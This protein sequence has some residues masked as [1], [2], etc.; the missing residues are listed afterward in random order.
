MK[1]KRIVERGG[2]LAIAITVCVFVGTVA[3]DSWNATDD[4]M[5]SWA[6]PGD[7]F[8]S[9]NPNY[10]WV[11]F[12]GAGN[13]LIPDGPFL[14]SD[15]TGWGTGSVNNDFYKLF[16]PGWEGHDAGI[17]G[18]GPS[19]VRFVVPAGISHAT[20]NVSGVIQQADWE[21]S[22]AMQ[23]E[24][25]GTAVVTATPDYLHHT[26]DDF[27]IHDVST[28]DVVE[29][30][31][32]GS[33]PDPTPTFSAW[34]VTIR[35]ANAQL[36]AVS[37]WKFD[38]GEGTIAYDSVS[39]NDGTIYGAT[40][41][42]GIVDGA[43]SFDGVDDYVSLSHSDAFNFGA[44]DFTVNLWAKF[45]STSGAQ[46]FLGRNGQ[47]DRS[48]SFYYSN[49]NLRFAWQ[50]VAYHDEPFAWIPSTDRWYHI[51][52]LRNGI[53]LKAFVDGSQIANTYNIGTDTVRE[54]TSVFYIGE[55]VEDRGYY[56][57]GTIDEV[58]IYNRALTA[59][60]IQQQYQNGLQ[61][62]GHEP[63][64]VSGTS[65]DGNNRLQLDGTLSS[66]PDGDSLTFNWQ[67]EGEATPRTG[68]IVSI[69]DLPVG[70]YQVTLTVDDGTYTDTDTM[71]L[72]VPAG[73]GVE[74]PPADALQEQVQNIKDRISCFS[75]SS[76]DA[77][78]EKAAE[79]R[80]KALLNMLDK[81]SE[82]IDTGDFQAAIDQLE[83]ILVKSDGLSPP[84]SPPD[85]I[86]DDPITTEINEQEEIAQSVSNLLIDLDALL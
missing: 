53:D 75:T 60:E 7:L 37:Y 49:S 1:T 21:P 11:Y 32:D 41:A 13:L 20:L 84:D 62:L 12:D 39:E 43:L 80:R 46:V 6:D 10:P 47:S 19:W 54:A 67:I 73:A 40:W 77:P 51:A 28:G 55:N 57:N 82:H 42:S 9:Y 83:D 27:L 16:R 4:F 48:W 45:T 5:A 79:N 3:A 71:L 70:N 56:F 63:I 68:Q 74:P 81:V 86:I 78:N 61:G 69:A 2:I 76:F 38:E 52:I 58:A 35:T 22:R 64:A 65:L 36:T 8:P 34:D 50:G 44:A 29:I 26:F 33:G 15:Q 18:H 31:L 14:W 59:E 24:I 85:W 72:G 30:K 23:M 25:N 17:T 66:D